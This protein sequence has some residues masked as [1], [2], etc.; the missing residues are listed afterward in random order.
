MPEPQ[1]SRPLTVLILEDE[2]VFALDLQYW[3]RGRG[4]Y[5][6]RVA[7]CAEEALDLAA[8]DTPDVV[9]VDVGLSG[10]RDGIDVARELATRYGVPIV[11]ITALD[12]ATVRRGAADLADA[13]V[14]TKPVDKD[15]L[16]RCLEAV[17]E[18]APVAASG[19]D[20]AAIP[21]VQ[22]SL[23]ILGDP[24]GQLGD[25][26]AA[27]GHQ[28]RHLPD[29][30]T[31]GAV[32]DIATADAFLVDLPDAG[33]RRGV[34]RLRRTHQRFPGIPV[35]VSSAGPALPAAQ[36]ALCG[37]HAY[38]RVPHDMDELDLVLLRLAGQRLTD[39]LQDQVSGLYDRVGFRALARQQLRAARRTGTKLAF[40][41]ADMPD[42]ADLDAIDR[43]FRQLG[44]AMR[45]TFRDAD[46][47]GRLDGSDCGVLLLNASKETTPI[48]MDRFRDKI[49]ALQAEAGNLGLQL[50]LAHFDPGEPC[51]LEELVARTVAQM[52]R[53]Q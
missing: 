22:L 37:V 44:P 21:R 17:R 2:L 36:A 51:S 29:S 15:L 24:R 11:F 30:V 10:E 12:A 43:T 53:G 27:H 18:G 38:L 1:T 32:Y 34:D 46:I 41:R 45:E 47:A 8:T 23:A 40:L 7:T 20:P 50:G 19:A 3:V 16:G 42:A 26:L 4:H 48:A 52:E 13:A 5:V 31:D 49:A 6:T 9:F 25:H 33:L 14:L 28:V 39:S 35:L